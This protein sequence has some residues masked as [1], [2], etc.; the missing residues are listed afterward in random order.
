[1][2]LQID[3]MKNG[4]LVVPFALNESKKLQEKMKSTTPTD[5]ADTTLAHYMFMKKHQS[6]N[7]QEQNCIFVVNLPL[8]TNQENLKKG[9]GQILAQYGA[10]AHISQLLHNDEFGLHDIDLSSLTSTLMSTGGVE[11]KRFTP[12][13]SALLQF[14]DS[15]SLDNAWSALR[16]YSQE[17]DSSKLA[18][19]TFESPSLETFTNFYKPIDTEYLKE[20][21]YS[22]MALFEQREQEA[23]EEAQSSIV[24]ED[25]F[26]LVVG[27]NTKSLNSIRKKILN[28]NPLLKHEKVVKPPTMVDKKAKQDFY[29]FQ[30][31]ERKK[32]EI[33]ELLKKFK[34]DQE[35]IKE[36]KSRR[37]FNPYT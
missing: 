13:N 35:K 12:R 17:R 33:S 32:Q 28:R 31:R 34:Q 5:E 14:I 6:K 19:W 10:V 37:R 30:I 16:K 24:D 9:M 3:S 23:Q 7:E 29:R 4:F 11:E 18:K 2:A 26:T 25:G 20:D 15:S 22:H 36:M 1:M 21:V 27:K 8:L